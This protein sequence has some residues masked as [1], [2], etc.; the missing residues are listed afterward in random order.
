MESL[1]IAAQ[2]NALR[3]NHIKARRDKT[4]QNSKRRLCGDRDETINHIKSECNK[5]AQK[6]YKARHDWVG[7]VIHREMCKKFKFD[8]T[9][10]W[11]MHNPSHVLQNDTHKLLWD[12]NIQTDHRLPARIPDLIIITKKKKKKENLQNCR[13]SCPGEPQ[14]KSEGK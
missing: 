5:L 4:Q 9:N 7:K 8:H 3:T 14:N 1:L 2:D 13:L 12:F 11:Y 10:K 6:A